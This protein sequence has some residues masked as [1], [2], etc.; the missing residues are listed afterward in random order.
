MEEEGPS[1]VVSSTSSVLPAVEG[2]RE[3]LDASSAVVPEEI[4]DSIEDLRLSETAVRRPD[5]N[6]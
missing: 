4:K 5:E 6:R 2:T 3:R 1:L